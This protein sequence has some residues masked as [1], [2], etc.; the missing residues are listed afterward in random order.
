[1]MPSHFVLLTYTCAIPTS[2]LRL[3]SALAG[4]AWMVNY[5]FMRAESI[6]NGCP[7]AKVTTGE[8]I[9]NNMLTE[10]KLGV[11][12][13]VHTYLQHVNQSDPNSPLESQLPHMA[14]FL[15]AREEHWYYFGS[16]GWWDNDYAWDALYDKASTCGKPTE[17][18]PAVGSGP[19]YTRAFE[20]CKVL[21]DCT[22]SSFCKGDIKFAAGE[23]TK[24]EG[25]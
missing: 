10:S 8:C 14:A 2:R 4:T 7:G 5:E 17:P 23:S 9:L 11:A 18:A 6:L 3:V 16:T 25:L 12:A 19:V 21:L 22:N 24:K 20:R 15:L 1:M 13:G